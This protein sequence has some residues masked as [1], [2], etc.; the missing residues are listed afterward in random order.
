MPSDVNLL[1]AWAG[2]L[3]GGV[4]GAI[5]GL[6]FHREHWLGG[7]ASWP[8]RLIRLGHIS[9]FG[10]GFIN[11]GF[12]LTCT[13]KD[14]HDGCGAASML[15][16][17]GAVTMPAVCYLSAWKPGFRHMFFIPALSVIA[18]IALFVGRMPRP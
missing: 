2:F 14:M 6:F 16:L 15:L 4:A 10:L 11:L 7:Y 5:P 18:G 12:S 8:R 13:A 1:A 3:L 17:I 9:F